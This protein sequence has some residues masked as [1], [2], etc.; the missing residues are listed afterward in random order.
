[1]IKALD[2]S[3]FMVGNGLR[4]RQEL[5]THRNSA[6]L[7][8]TAF[9]AVEQ[10]HSGYYLEFGIVACSRRRNVRLL[11]NDPAVPLT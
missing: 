2:S 7:W 11:Q 4:S 5:C 6:P 3:P 9:A 8:P 1:M 10:V